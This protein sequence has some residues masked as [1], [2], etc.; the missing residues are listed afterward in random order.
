MTRR[1]WLMLALLLAF[2]LA[3]F[4]VGHTAGYRQGVHDTLEAVLR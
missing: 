4:W 2:Q 1:S 3:T